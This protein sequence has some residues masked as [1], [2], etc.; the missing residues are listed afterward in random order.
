MEGPSEVVSGE[1]FLVCADDGNITF[2]EQAR[3]MA[4]HFKQYGFS[5]AVT[6]SPHWLTKLGGH[7]FPSVKAAANKLDCVC[8]VSN[9][10]AHAQL[11]MT[12]W[13]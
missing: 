10:K 1:R 12:Q 13:R 2:V 11:G 3:M 5:P 4:K 6:T 9:N 7:L 8:Y